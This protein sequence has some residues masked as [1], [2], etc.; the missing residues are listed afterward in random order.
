M[1]EFDKTKDTLAEIIS[2]LDRIESNI[3]SE[4]F[5]FFW[6]VG[7][8]LLGAILGLIFWMLG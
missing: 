8:P 3:P 2:K 7:F 6:L 4:G 5:I 1:S